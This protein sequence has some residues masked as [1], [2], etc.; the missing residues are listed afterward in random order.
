MLPSYPADTYSMDM[1]MGS[2]K[3]PPPGGKLRAT[4]HILAL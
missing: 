4:I 3:Y 2:N 1:T